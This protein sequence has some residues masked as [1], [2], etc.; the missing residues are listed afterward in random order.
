LLIIF[1]YLD[2]LHMFTYEIKFKL[3]WIIKAS[4]VLS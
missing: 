2:A 1:E 3:N 4:N